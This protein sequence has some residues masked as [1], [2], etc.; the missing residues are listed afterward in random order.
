[1]TFVLSSTC[2]R[3]GRNLKL[4]NWR[5]FRPDWNERI[6]G[7]RYRVP[8]A[9]VL[10]DQSQFSALHRLEALLARDDYYN[11]VTIRQKS[12]RKPSPTAAA[13]C[14]DLGKCRLG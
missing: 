14:R 7:K 11:P 1:M 6:K 5:L 10:L 2:T 13:L 12:V 3:L 4:A 8:F 9:P